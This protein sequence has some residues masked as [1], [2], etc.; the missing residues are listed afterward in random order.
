MAYSEE[1]DGLLSS[2]VR[3]DGIFLKIGIEEAEKAE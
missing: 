2:I 1:L 3:E